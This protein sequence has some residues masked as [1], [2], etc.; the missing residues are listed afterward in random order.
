MQDSRVSMEVGRQLRQSGQWRFDRRPGRSGLARGARGARGVRWTALHQPARRVR[1]KYGR[2]GGRYSLSGENRRA[3]N[4][5]EP[6]RRAA[7]RNMGLSLMC[8]RR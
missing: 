3:E 1:L 8:G 2:T 4:R 6:P 7:L 5:A